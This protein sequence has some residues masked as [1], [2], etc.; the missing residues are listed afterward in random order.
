MTPSVSR[1][2]GR[3]IERRQPAVVGQ[4]QFHGPFIA[5]RAARRQVGPPFEREA[6]GL[7]LVGRRG[8]RVERLLGHARRR[9]ALRLA[10][11]VAQVQ[12]QVDGALFEQAFRGDERRL[13]LQDGAAIVEPFDRRDLSEGDGVGQLRVARLGEVEQG[14]GH[15]ALTGR[16]HPVPI[17]PESGT[18]GREAR[19][20]HGVFRAA[21]REGRD[22]ARGPAFV[23]GA[24]AQQRQREAGRELGDA[25]G[26]GLA[27]VGG[28]RAGARGDP[29]DGGE[30]PRRQR[31]RQFQRGAV[32]VVVAARGGGA[33]LERGVERAVGAAPIAARRHQIGPRLLEQRERA[34]HRGQQL[35]HGERGRRRRDRRRLR[36]G[37]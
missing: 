21:H 31:L 6:H 15:A 32:V 2:L 1:V 27:V 24:A 23:D 12:G 10:V 3:E 5:P 26:V 8:R 14:P 17:D 11:R 16:G 28:E 34:I 36:G 18:V 4:S 19:L 20:I 30:A 7:G 25:L 33:A 37:G 29:A 35:R 9:R 22:L 13:P